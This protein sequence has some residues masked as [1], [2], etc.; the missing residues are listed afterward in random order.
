MLK[1][2]TDPN[3]VQILR[4]TL[5]LMIQARTLKDEGLP[6][7]AIARRL[8]LH[9]QTVAKYLAQLEEAGA[10]TD[11][12]PAPRPHR[13]DPYIPYLAARLNQYPELAA[14]RLFREIRD[15]GYPG[16]WRTV[17]RYV[18]TLKAERP[19]RVYQPYETGPG[20]QAQVDWGH[21]VWAPD[22]TKIYCFAF[23]LSYSRLRYVEYPTALDT[24]TFLNSLTR[25]FDYIGGVPHK[26][27]FDNAK[28]VVSER[29]GRVV[30]FHPDLLAFA[31]AYGFQP[32]ACW[33]E[34]PE[35]KGKVES[36]VGYVHR[37]FYYGTP[38]ADYAALHQ[39]ARA[40]CDRVNGEVHAT[41]Q[42]RPWERWEAER[43]PRRPLPPQRPA[44]FRVQS[45]RV[46][47]ASTF[48][49][50]QNQYSVPKDYARRTVRLEIFEHEFRALA[51]DQELGRWPRT[52]QKGQ[53]F[54]EPAH[55]ADRFQGTKRS[56]LEHQFRNVC[57]A[58]PQYLD[59]LAAARGSSLR[60]QMQQIVGLAE[61]YSRTEL[62]QA[63]TRAL[64]FKNFGYGALHRILQTQQTAPD[65]LPAVPAAARDSLPGVPVVAVAQRDPAYYAHRQGGA[66]AWTSSSKG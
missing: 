14:K 5:R 17:R 50:R 36:T 11:S 8:G 1:L 62:Q 16:S 39:Q 58:A 21:E 12:L 47:K 64:A 4:E 34:D 9:R 10:M 26:I 49:F 37:D 51:G 29:V 44:L 6:V 32:E 42:A 31:L 30:R 38:F 23:V 13:I 53:R 22:G 45:V 2:T 27:L 61:T 25:A 54:L 48:T 18:A 7:T 60:E 15:Q 40:W 63:M 52:T 59:G 19:Q 66:I 46:T 41:T 33:V 28:V 57:D 65:A 56:A 20:E 55:Y 35:T 43:A 3:E 24:V